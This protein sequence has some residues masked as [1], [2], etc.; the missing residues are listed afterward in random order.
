M[1]SFHSL[2]ESVAFMALTSDGCWGELFPSE[3]NCSL[4]TLPEIASLCPV[5]PNSATSVTFRMLLF[6]T[7]MDPIIE[8]FVGA[9][10]QQ[11]IAAQMAELRGAFQIL[12][13]GV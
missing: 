7:L 8:Q 10:Q 12:L 9:W 3:L 2:L 4:V 5:F 6:K 1:C 11:Q 13:L